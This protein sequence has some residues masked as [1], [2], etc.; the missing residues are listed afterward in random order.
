MAQCV[1]RKNGAINTQFL[2]LSWPTEHHRKEGREYKFFFIKKE[3]KIP[4]VLGPY[5][6]KTLK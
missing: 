1:I 3:G 6:P 2:P 4:N 5:K